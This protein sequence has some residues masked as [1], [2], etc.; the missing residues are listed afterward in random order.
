MDFK[1]FTSYR[2]PLATGG[3]FTAVAVPDLDLSDVRA[4]KEALDKQ[5]RTSLEFHGHAQL[6]AAEFESLSQALRGTP[7][8]RLSLRGH[9]VDSAA[10]NHIADALSENSDMSHLDLRGCQLAND[11]IDGLL[12]LLRCRTLQTLLLDDNQ[13]GEDIE[14]QLFNAASS[15]SKLRVLS[16]TGNPLGSLFARP[17]W[18][19]RQG[20]STS[21][22]P[23]VRDGGLAMT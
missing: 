13:L 19:T 16:L 17:A 5:N 11:A 3:A 23:S 4:L 15:F 21:A 8:R 9:H 12:R 1:L 6:Q 10:L 7:V 20:T 2:P 22:W 14:L 18:E